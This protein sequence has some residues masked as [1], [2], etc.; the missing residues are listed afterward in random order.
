MSVETKSDRVRSWATALAE[1]VKLL[2]L[3]IRTA[4]EIEPM[5]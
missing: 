5:L 3:V 2:L 1:W 4:K